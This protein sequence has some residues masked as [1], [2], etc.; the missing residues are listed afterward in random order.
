M[1]L[2]SWCCHLPPAQS[3]GP[4][5]KA[6]A[7]TSLSLALNAASPLALLIPPDVHSWQGKMDYLKYMHRKG[8]LKQNSPIHT[9][10]SQEKTWQKIHEWLRD[11]MKANR[12][13]KVGDQTATA[14]STCRD[15][16]TEKLNVQ[17]TE[18][19]AV[20]SFHP[21]AHVHDFRS[22]NYIITLSTA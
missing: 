15:I 7:N 11:D 14:W 2:L 6:W 20:G 1:S 4:W 18:K 10:H 13:V 8:N 16:F 12:A 21:L 22:F 19:S 5:G 9:K 3:S 17:K